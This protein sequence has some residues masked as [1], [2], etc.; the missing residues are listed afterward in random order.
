MG[1]GELVLALWLDS[2]QSVTSGIPLLFCVG[3]GMGLGSA[4]GAR[5]CLL[6]LQSQNAINS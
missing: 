6:D 2:F 5:S 3:E 4:Q 1:I